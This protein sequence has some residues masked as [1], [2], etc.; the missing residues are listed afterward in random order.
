MA[1]QKKDKKSEEQEGTT[2]GRRLLFNK[3]SM[4]YK[5]VPAKEGEKPRIFQVGTAIEPL[6][7]KE[8]KDL[9]DYFGIVYADTIMPASTD[10]AD[11]VVAQKRVAELTEENEKLKAT[12]EKVSKAKS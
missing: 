10:K 7:D 11:L 4:A 5:L 6:N 12:L 1:D 2:T 3:S 9:L 8:E